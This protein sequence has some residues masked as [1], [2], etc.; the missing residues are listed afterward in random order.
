MQ[1]QYINEMLN[2]PEL[3]INQVLSINA[4][5]LHIEAEPLC[6]KQCCPCCG[7]DQAVI[8]KGSNNIRIVRHLSVF[9]KKTYLHVPSTRLLCTRCKAGFVWMYEFVGPKQRYSRLFR[10]HTAEQAFGSTAAHSARMQQAPV[11]TVQRIHNE[12]VPVEYERICEQVWEEAK[13]TAD[14]VLGVDDFAIKKGHAYN[15][16]IHNLKGETMLDLLPGRKLEELR[17]YAQEHPDFLLLNPKAVVLNLARAY[18]TWISECFPNAIRIADRFHVHGYVI[19]SVQEVRKTVQNTLSSRAKAHLKAN[20]RLLNPPAESLGEES[21][22]RWEALLNYSPLLRS[23]WEWKEAFTTWYDCSPDLAIARLGFERWCEQGDRIDHAAVRS[24]LKTMRNWKE[25]I[26][27]YHHCRWTN[28][29]V[30][31]RHNRIKAFQRRH[32]FTR[33]RS[34]YKA[35]ILIECNRHRILG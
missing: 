31:G 23:V 11:S 26:V 35:G 22:K 12:A 21:K 2:L 24:A 5:E 6:D 3:K 16:G 14:L 19:E 32:Y 30:E 34:R 15:T 27:N 18:H 8:R 25:E 17:S 20:H 1:T 29:T 4:D 33:N 28:A 7:S 13:E 10:S 9:E